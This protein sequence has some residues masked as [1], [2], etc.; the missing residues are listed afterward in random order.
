MRVH[1]TGLA[2]T[3]RIVMALETLLVICVSAPVGA[4]PPAC[5]RDIADVFQSAD[6]AVLAEP[7]E[8]RKT[9][10]Y[11]TKKLVGRYRVIERFK[12]REKIGATIRVEDHCLDRPLPRGMAGY[13]VGSQK[14]V[15]GRLLTSPINPPCGR[16]LRHRSLIL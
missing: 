15:N 6:I 7:V 12:G 11:D 16:A 13:S 14:S 1:D 3:S 2:M 9:Q 4:S 10:R 8:A 5:G